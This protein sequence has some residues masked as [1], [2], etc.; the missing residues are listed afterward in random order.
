MA[1]RAARERRRAN[2]PEGMRR[3]VLDAAA[4][5]FQSRGYHSTSTQE[6]MREAGV[7]GGALHHH[8]PTKKALG[9]A[10]IRE[11]VAGTVEE[12]W[13]APF[14][15]APTAAEGIRTVFG[16][17]L[18]GL[19]RRGTVVGCPLNNL[20]LELS[21]ADADFRS[22]LGAVFEEWQAAVARKL[23]TERGAGTAA[24]DG[25]QDGADTL[26]AFIVASYSGAMAMAKTAQDTAP[27]EACARQLVRLLDEPGRGA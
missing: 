1:E 18:D 5:A 6:V 15:S 11:R 23:R 2:D 10:V 21:L 7:T 8:F 24:Q 4:A 12:T 14:V 26:A 3:R 20:A 25:T 22:A 17:I 13:I 27:L 16:R 9:L 19:N